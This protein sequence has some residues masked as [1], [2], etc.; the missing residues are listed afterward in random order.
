MAERLWNMLKLVPSISASRKNSLITGL[1]RIDDNTEELI[2]SLYH[3]PD[4][5]DFTDVKNATYYAWNYDSEANRWNV[6]GELK[7]K[8]GLTFSFKRKVDELSDGIF[9]TA[10]AQGSIP[11]K[12]NDVLLASNPELFYQKLEV[13]PETVE[14]QQSTER[15]PPAEAEDV[16]DITPDGPVKMASPELGT[17]EVIDCE[18]VW[19][20]AIVVEHKEGEISEKPLVNSKEEKYSEASLSDIDEEETSKA[21]TSS[22]ISDL[23]AEITYPEFPAESKTALA[24]N[25]GHDSE[26]EKFRVGKTEVRGEEQEEKLT[27]ESKDSEEIHQKLIH[28]YHDI[29]VENVFGL[30]KDRYSIIKDEVDFHD[31]W[32][33]FKEYFHDLYRDS[34]IKSTYEEVQKD[35]VDIMEK[36]ELNELWSKLEGFIQELLDLFDVKKWAKNAKEWLDVINTNEWYSK[37]RSYSDAILEEVDLG[38]LWFK[39]RCWIENLLEKMSVDEMMIWV[40]LKVQ[41]IREMDANEL[42]VEAID[43]FKQFVDQIKMP[44]LKMAVL[45]VAFKEKMN[46]VGGFFKRIKNKVDP[47]S[48]DSQDER[49]YQTL[50]KDKKSYSDMQ[51]YHRPAQF[52]TEIGQRPAINPSPNMFN[53]MEDGLAADYDSFAQHEHSNANLFNTMEENTSWNSNSY[54]QMY[55]P[56][57]FKSN[58]AFGYQE[59][60]MAHNPYY[61]QYAHQQPQFGQGQSTGH[62]QQPMGYQQN[63]MLYPYPGY[64]M[65]RGNMYY[66]P[67]Q[68]CQNCF[69]FG[70]D[71]MGDPRYFYDEEDEGYFFITPDGEIIRKS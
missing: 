12:P 1:A 59:M 36:L 56:Y 8:N 58:P 10:E 54:N 44:E 39:V 37:V 42:R 64:G 34:K 35:L 38:V 6:L 2:L 19:E 43:L 46:Q 28:F 23:K 11:M 47:I 68:Q 17:E 18:P 4:P 15:R 33:K 69:R 50:E 49:Q 60:P 48:Q 32:D 65:N 53:D 16:V 29:P 66:C 5:K 27:M 7:K 25:V 22:Q 52:K 51:Y 57:M 30:I 14:V 21:Q 3:L 24:A 62:Q 45:K 26:T 61:Q 31:Y 40:K 13:K 55:D 41:S 70:Y 63:P 9:V 20:E 71:A 67:Y